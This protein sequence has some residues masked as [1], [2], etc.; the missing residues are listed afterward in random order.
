MMESQ[1]LLSKSWSSCP[2]Q[3]FD[4]RKNV[5]D[6]CQQLSFSEQDINAIVLAI[7]EACT[8]IIRYAYGD[9]RDGKIQIAVS[10]DPSQVIFRLH[11][12]AKHVSRDCLK[13]KPTPSLVPGGLGVQLMQEIMDSVEFVHTSACKGNI[14]EMKKDL[15]QEKI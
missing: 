12:F 7:D 15:P 1:K 10:T 2:N 9:C 11:D 13:M 6:I 5:T 8:N 4:I 14:L 3:L